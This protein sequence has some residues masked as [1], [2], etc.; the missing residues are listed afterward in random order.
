V[1]IILEPGTSVNVV[2]ILHNCRS[3]GNFLTN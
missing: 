1:Q 3:W 2:T